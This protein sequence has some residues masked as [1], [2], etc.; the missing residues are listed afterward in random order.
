MGQYKI[1]SNK[2]TLGEIGTFVSDEALNGL[3]IEALVDGGHI[4]A[5]ATK[6]VKQDLKE[7]DK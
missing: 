1:V 7:S 3:N 2:T 5:S 6:T 4:E